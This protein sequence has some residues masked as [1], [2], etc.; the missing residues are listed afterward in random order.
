MIVV[1]FL[2][3]AGRAHAQASCNGVP[4]NPQGA[5]TWVPQ[6]CEEFNAGTPGSP[7]TTV[8]AF[9]LGNNN[10]WGN[11]ELEVYCG[12]PGYAG[13]P[14]GCPSTFSTSTSNAYLDGNG[15]LVIQAINNNGT[16]YS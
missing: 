14:S 1:L 2:V 15:H 16:W 7:D 10:G 13:N 12:P 5:V 8:W 4:N 6:W 9:G 11:N 3:G